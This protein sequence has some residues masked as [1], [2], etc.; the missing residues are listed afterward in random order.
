M[1][2]S[3]QR[4]RK[5]LGNTKRKRE[6]R[7]REREKER[8]RERRLCQH[9]YGG[10]GPTEA[11]TPMPCSPRP[12]FLGRQPASHQFHKD[13]TAAARFAQFSYAANRWRYS[14]NAPFVTDEVEAAERSGARSICCCSSNF[15]P[16]G[17]YPALLT[18]I[19]CALTRNSTCWRPLRSGG[20]GKAISKAEWLGC[21]SL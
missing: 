5:V 2:R 17:I 16:F 19:S 3:A 14:L 6:N 9:S 4:A 11:R 10:R 8:E 18:S 13:S 21:M 15:V 12:R 7:E 20:S 1:S